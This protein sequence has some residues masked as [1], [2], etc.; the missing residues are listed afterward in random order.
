MGSLPGT[1]RQTER[2][3]QEQPGP[4]PRAAP[5][6]ALRCYPHSG[7]H[8]TLPAGSLG[9]N[10]SPAAAGPGGQHAVSDCPTSTQHKPDSKHSPAT[11]T[12]CPCRLPACGLPRPTAPLRT[13][14]APLSAVTVPTRLPARKSRPQDSL[15]VG[16]GRFCHVHSST[17]KWALPQGLCTAVLGLVI[18]AAGASLPGSGL[19]PADA[20]CS[21]RASWGPPSGPRGR[22][23]LSC[24]ATRQVTPAFLR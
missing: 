14:A 7:R 6:C 17:R 1:C 3:V 21:P 11:H 22:R 8:R 12:G 2:C 13:P 20:S 23:P 15:P 19:C 24:A 9:P 4:A 16:T 18:K 5:T 10:R